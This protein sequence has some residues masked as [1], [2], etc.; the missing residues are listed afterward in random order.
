MYIVIKIYI[1]TAICW[2]RDG[3][4]LECIS[5]WSIWWPVSGSGNFHV[6]LWMF[7]WGY[8]VP[9]CHPV[10]HYWTFHYHS[11][12][13]LVSSRRLFFPT[14]G[15]YL[16]SVP[17]LC[18][19][20]Q[21]SLVCCLL[22]IL[23]KHFIIV[24]IIWHYNPLWV[25]AFSAKSLQVLLSLAISFQFLTLSF[26]RSSITS[27]CH[28]CL[29]LPIGLIP[30]GFQ[31]SS[32]LAGLA[33]SILWICPSHYLS[34]YKS[35]QFTSISHNDWKCSMSFLTSLESQAIWEGFYIP[36][37]LFGEWYVAL[38]VWRAISFFKLTLVL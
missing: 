31:S 20:S 37:L 7:L 30:I 33:W 24:I 18:W 32:F 21:W 25:F 22:G 1:C 36:A 15:S 5:I 11:V 17:T 29:G 28:R 9:L 26:F 19:S 27:S 10:F 8:Y 2:H 13:L 4:C 12:L 38:A 35:V 3:L 14:S 16:L 34:V 6:P 23:H